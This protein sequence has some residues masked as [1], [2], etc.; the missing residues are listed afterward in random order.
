MTPEFIPGA[1]SCCIL[2]ERLGSVSGNQH[3][4]RLFHDLL[5]TYYQERARWWFDPHLHM[6][7][8][9]YGLEIFIRILSLKASGTSG[10]IVVMVLLMAKLLVISL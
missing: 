5:L 7:L 10:V 9:V 2:H 4:V 8:K 1:V 6:V 3:L